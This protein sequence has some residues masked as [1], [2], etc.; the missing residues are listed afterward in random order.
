MQEKVILEL[1]SRPEETRA[2][3]NMAQISRMVEARDLAALFEYFKAVV[4]VQGEVHDS[5]WIRR[6]VNWSE[7]N[8]GMNTFE[9]LAWAEIV[10]TLC[11][12]ENEYGADSHYPIE[13][14]PEDAKRLQDRVN[15]K[16]FKQNFSLAFIGFVGMM[17]AAIAESKR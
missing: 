1:I 8:E 11:A 6:L 5:H 4:D 2:L 3:I 10:K 17:E 7:D 12:A 16:K 13:I 9:M 15:N 14:S